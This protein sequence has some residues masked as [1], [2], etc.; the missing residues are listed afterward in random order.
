[1]GTSMLDRSL[2]AEMRDRTQVTK[3]RAP[4]KVLRVITPKPWNRDDFFA[5]L[6]GR[7]GQPGALARAHFAHVGA[8]AEAARISPSTISKWKNDKQ[9]PTV[10]KLTAIANA[11]QVPRRDVL[12]IAGLLDEDDIGRPTPARL[13]EDHEPSADERKAIATIRASNLAKP[14]QDMLIKQEL[15]RL[16][17]LREQAE[18]QLQ[19]TIKNM[20]KVQ[21]P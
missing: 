4:A 16:R 21:G 11:L 15:E 7:G 13:G 6:E 19:Q 9:R 20:E 5:W 8:L 17:L 1:V 18:A 3:S 12:L 2:T 14:L 10:D